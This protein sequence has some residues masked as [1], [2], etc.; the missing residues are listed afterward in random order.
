ML[1]EG[2][3]YG[4]EEEEEMDPL[5]VCWYCHVREKEEGSRGE[6]LASL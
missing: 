6:G 3:G 1:E 4:D 2:N 5:W